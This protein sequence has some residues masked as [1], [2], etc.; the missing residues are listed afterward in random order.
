M[1]AAI[2]AR[3]TVLAAFALAL[4]GCSSAPPRAEDQRPVMSQYKGWTIRAAPSVIY[5]SPNLWRARVRVWPP[6]VWPETHPGIELSFDGAAAERRTI[7]QAATAT[8]RRYI[9]ASV[10]TH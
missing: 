10:S 1:I 9:D 8:A 3:A 6:E 2:Y 5:G 7:E 4:L